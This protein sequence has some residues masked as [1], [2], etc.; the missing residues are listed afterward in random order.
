MNLLQR[1]L[2]CGEEE[3]DSIIET[4]INEANKNAQPIEKL[5]FTEYGKSNSLFKGFIPFKTRIKYCSA[6]IEDYGMETTDF[7]YEFAKFIRKY[8]IK[9]KAA[10][11]YNLEF[12][13]NSYFGY[14]GKM[15]RETIFNEHAWNTTTTDDEYFEALRN[16][17]LGD[18]RGKGAAQCTERGA[19]AQ[20]I[21]SLFEVESYYCMG[22]VSYGDTEEAHCFNIVKT[23]EGY[24]LVDYSVTITSYDQDGDELE[25]HW[26]ISDDILFS[27]RNVRYQF[28]N[29]GIHNITLTASDEELSNSKSISIVAEGAQGYAEC[30]LVDF[31]VVQNGNTFYITDTSEGRNTF[32]YD[33]KWTLD[34]TD[35]ESTG[36]TLTLVLSD[37]QRHTLT[38]T[39]TAGRFQDSVDKYLYADVS[40]IIS[41]S[42]VIIDKGTSIELD[43]TNSFAIEDQ[44]NSYEWDEV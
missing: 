7:F 12:F 9:S 29:T 10:L 6:S 43:G 24:A 36:D 2:E 13:I 17:K 23:K 11:I 30:V 34:G 31:S 20:Q 5:G 1:I 44:V 3:L 18:L 21:L 8:N 41:V 32:G 22:C 28:Q 27:S 40:A 16:N 35:L 4:A 42:S 37:K 15:D 38:L 14:P 33:R 19:L 25:Y 39:C 26:K